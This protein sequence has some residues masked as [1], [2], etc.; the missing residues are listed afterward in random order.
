MH[1]ELHP[2]GRLRLASPRDM[3]R[4]SARCQPGTEPLLAQLLG[5]QGEV[6]GEGHVWLTPALLSN[7]AGPVADAA[8]HEGFR[9]M[10]DYAANKGWLDNK[11]RVRAHLEAVP[12]TTV[13]EAGFRALMRRV[14]AA[15]AIAATGEAD[16]RTGITVSSIATVCA[17]PPTLS[18][19]V[20]RSS[21]S[22]DALALADHVALSFLGPAHAEIARAF[23]GA[24]PAAER[25]D[26]GQWQTGVTGM[27]VLTDAAGSC[28][29]EILER[30]TI[31]THTLLVVSVLTASVPSDS[32][33]ML[34]F[35]GRLTTPAA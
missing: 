21:G 22:H 28:E 12:E 17:D 9:R 27:P 3:K 7:L 6:T 29:C 25:F 24:V 14:P 11:G 13:P 31:G 20:N 35:D 32:Q 2:N 1:V 15:V 26:H 30:I 34:N 16:A 5:A 18:F 19:C 23:A 10:L 4:L 8:W 33:P